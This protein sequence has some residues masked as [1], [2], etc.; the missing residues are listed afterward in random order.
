MR[1][2]AREIATLADEAGS[3]PL[4]RLLDDG[5]RF[6]ALDEQGALLFPSH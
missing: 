1:T 5:S 6:G 4:R 2:L 3:S